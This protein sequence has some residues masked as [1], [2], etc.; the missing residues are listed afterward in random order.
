MSVLVVDAS[1]IVT[2]VADDG[3]DGTLVRSMLRGERLAAPEVLDLEVISVLRRLAATG[4]IT[5]KRASLALADLRDLPIQRASHVMLVD[6]CWE[7]RANLTPYDAA[8]VA[9]AEICE[10]PLLTAD[11]RLASAPGPRCRIEVITGSGG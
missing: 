4:R 7:L 1:V 8:Y 5:S 11:A 6:R 3:D 9:L 10:S 2:A